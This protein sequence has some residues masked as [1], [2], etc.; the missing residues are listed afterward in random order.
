VKVLIVAP[1][2]INTPHFETELELAQ[3][4]LDQGDEV[5]VLGCDASLLACD[6]NLHH[7]L[8]VCAA[9]I[10]R[11]RAGLVLLSEPVA[12][13]P[14]Y[15][16]QR[17]DQQEAR[18]LR[19]DFSDIDDLK[20]YAIE[21]FDIGYAVLSTLISATRNAEPDIHSIAGR[22]LLQNLLVSAFGVYRSLRNHL[23]ANNF[24]RVYVY[25]GRFA[26]TRAVLRACEAEGV[27]CFTHEKGGKLEHYAL[28]RNTTSHN[29]KNAHRLINEAWQ[30]ANPNLRESIASEFYTDRAKGI[31][32]GWFAF[33]LAQTEGLLPDEWDP[34]KQNIAVFLSSEDEFAALDDT[35]RNPLYQ[36]QVDGVN[37]IVDSLRDDPRFHVYIRVHPNLKN[38]TSRQTAFFAQYHPSN[39]TVIPP[40]SP[41]SS[42]SLMAKATKVITFG[43]T[44][45]AEATFWGVPSILVGPS[46]YRGLGATHNPTSHAQ[47]MCMLRIELSVMDKTGALKFGY[48]LKTF[49]IPFKY[50]C[51]EGVLEGKFK[52]VR[53]LPTRNYRR[54]ERIL[55]HRTRVKR[56]LIGI[57]LLS[58]SLRI[59]INPQNRS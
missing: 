1:Y 22:V 28:Y 14:L 3:I 18:L 39:G 35:W 40:E 42:Y 59:G 50:Y 58:D 26:P 20:S 15:L 49:G 43:S 37:Q 45:G 2:A 36:D 27:D 29:Q 44:V 57:S 55:R 5:I 52:S 10:G 9:C 56:L 12:Q 32:P 53:I 31:V 13:L 16:L 8:S 47:L 41:I 34:R 51:P 6:V 54:I 25:N 21:N 24:D 11:R 30:A 33:T 48:Y 17:R 4:H 46:L 7:D 19:H 23:S 38:V